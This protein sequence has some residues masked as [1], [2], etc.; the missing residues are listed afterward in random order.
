MFQNIMLLKYSISFEKFMFSLK[1]MYINVYACHFDS[2]FQ[3]TS[4]DSKMGFNELVYDLDV[5][6]NNIIIII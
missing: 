6:I 3:S 2:Y 5:T 4:L 1:L